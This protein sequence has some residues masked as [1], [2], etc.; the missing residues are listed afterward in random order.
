MGELLDH[1]LINPN[2]L[3]SH[4]VDVQDNPFGSVAMHIPSDNDDFVHPMQA[5]GTTIFFDSRTPTNN[6]L[7]NC[8]HIVLSSSN[9]W[10]PRD[11]QFPTPTQYHSEEGRSI[12]KTRSSTSTMSSDVPLFDM[13]IHNLE[14]RAL[15]CVRSD[16]MVAEVYINQHEDMPLD[17]PL[18]KTFA[19]SKRHARVTAQEL[20]E[21]CLIGLTQAHET[22]KVTT[23]NC[24]SA[25]LPL[26][27]RY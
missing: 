9:E 24:I 17:V 23:Q 1:S 20:S 16:R 2:Q 19:T 3:C 21:R 7:D 25:V 13:S 18:P 27:R 6:E 22:I 4:K 26:S 10:N 8:P 14:A 12:H 5:D 11:V 15:T